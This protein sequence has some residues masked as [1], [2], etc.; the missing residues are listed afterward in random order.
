MVRKFKV[1]F[2]LIKLFLTY[3]WEGVAFASVSRICNVKDLKKFIHFVVGLYT[4]E[5]GDE[6]QR[7]VCATIVLEMN[8]LG[9]S[10]IRH[11]HKE[12]IPLICLGRNDPLTEVST[13]FQEAWNELGV[14]S[15]YRLYTDEILSSVNK[16]LGSSSRTLKK[17]AALTLRDLCESIGKHIEPHVDQ[18][19][20]L[21][22][23]SLRGK[24]WEGKEAI[25]MA[26]VS[27]CKASPKEVS[28]PSKMTVKRPTAK[29]LVVTVCRLSTTSDN[30]WNRHAL[31]A[32][33]EMLQLFEVDVFEQISEGVVKTLEKEKQT[34]HKDESQQDV[35]KESA[36]HFLVKAAAWKVLAAAWPKQLEE[37][38]RHLKEMLELISKHSRSVWNV[39]L[40]VFGCLKK[41]LQSCMS[42][43]LEQSRS[44]WSESEV[45]GVMELVLDASEDKFAV[46]RQV[47]LEA[48]LELMNGLSD[49]GMLQKHS[50]AI[51]EK[52]KKLEQDPELVNII[53][54]LKNLHKSEP[55]N[56]KSKN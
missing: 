16:N 19:L 27:L 24:T 2:F 36:K 30:G 47:A 42:H 32:I 33:A 40:E 11:F 12:L 53:S 55:P 43:P 56:K 37:Q 22:A 52:L 29:D 48:L 49:S 10:E 7:E 34:P 35:Q 50:Q 8:K 46:V 23:E 5:R 41:V 44:L 21:L 54:S 28:N 14:P 18:E 1:H 51:E 13:I 4:D 9:T 31:N 39:K 6:K 26:L 20:I 38:K 45:E 15:A 25:L 17:Q 3:F